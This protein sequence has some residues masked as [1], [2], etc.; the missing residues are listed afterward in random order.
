MTP[1]SQQ[2]LGFA[3]RIGVLGTCCLGIWC[4]LKFAYA[5]YLFKQETEQS[6]RRATTVVPDGWEYFMGLADLDEEHAKDLLN[7]SL[8]LNHY[9]AAADIE[10][11]FQYE[12]EG[13]FP[14]AEKQL[15]TAYDVDRTYVP[16]WSLANYYL[17]RQNMQ[18][19]W[20][21]ARKAAEMPSDDLQELF[22]LC[23]SASPDASRITSA[24]LTDNPTL[25][26]QYINFLIT[27][28]QPASV[29]AVAP[30]LIRLGES[31]IDR[32]LLFSAVDMSVTSKDGAAAFD[33]WR[34]MK[35]QKCIVADATTPNNEA[36][37]RDP[38]PVR[39]DWSLPEYAGLHSWP[40]PAGLES[41]F[42]GTE[43]EDCTIAEQ[44]LVLAPGRYDL[45]FAYR[46]S[47]IAPD[48]G[49]RWQ[50][51]DEVS[52]AVL[53]QSANLSSEGQVFSGLGFIV[54][55]ASSLLRLRL[56]YHREVGTPRISGK[57]VVASTDIRP[58]P[59]T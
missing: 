45:S 17:R 30:R 7:T 42:T 31:E 57:L 10:L 6:V 41:E 36:F 3:V 50:V 46:T 40:G 14:R 1:R 55:P 53:G 23:W 33:I 43:P 22:D 32:P 16:R 11:G 27:K 44:E 13:D 38:L 5:D 59:Q 48:T 37:A 51:I 24:I 4:S 58:V 35:D 34:Q 9:N 21:W 39:F 25:I 15:L 29:A 18:A 47:G 8:N 19:F 52:G 54:P 20:E 49:I 28:N 56:G 26:R 12:D 2:L